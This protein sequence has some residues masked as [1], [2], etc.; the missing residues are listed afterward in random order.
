[1]REGFLLGGGGGGGCFSLLVLFYAECTARGWRITVF[2]VQVLSLEWEGTARVWH[3][4]ITCVQSKTPRVGMYRPC[5][6]K[7]RFFCASTIPRV[8]RYRPSVA[9]NRYVCAK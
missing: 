1:M 5:V 8:G 6:A 2:S 9:Y 4:T 3:I 7:I